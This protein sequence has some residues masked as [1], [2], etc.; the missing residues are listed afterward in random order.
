MTMPF[1]KFKGVE[2]SKLPN[3][4]VAWL[5]RSDILKSPLKEQVLDM[6]WNRILV[7]MDSNKQ[8]VI[9]TWIHNHYTHFSYSPS[10]YTDVRMSCEDYHNLDFYDV[11]SDCLPNQ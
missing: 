2:L 8:A 7:T 1:G 9:E 11:M 3:N 10:E 4:Y 6:V 5:L